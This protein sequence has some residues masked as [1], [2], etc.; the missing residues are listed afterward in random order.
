MQ[1]FKKYLLLMMVLAF[2]PAV[3]HAELSVKDTTSPEFIY[4]QGYSTEVSRIIDVKTVDPVSPIPAKEKNVWKNIGWTILNTIDPS[5]ER[6][7]TFVNHN[8]EYKYST[9]ES[10]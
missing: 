5:Y 8:T 3:A 2:A 4:N 6:P 9:P 1:T 7:N 10:L